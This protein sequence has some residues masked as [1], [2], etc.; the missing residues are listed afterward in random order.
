MQA[1][2][3]C[4]KHIAVFSW[5]DEGTQQR[6]VSDAGSAKERPAAGECGLYAG[7]LQT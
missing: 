2:A 3:S 7:G 4:L 6:T 1:T 5:L